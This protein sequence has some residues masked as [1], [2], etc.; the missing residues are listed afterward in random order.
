MGFCD[1]LI[2]VIADPVEFPH[3]GVIVGRRCVLWFKTVYQVP[4]IRFTGKSAFLD[5]LLKRLG[6]LLSSQN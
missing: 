2:E 3:H 5:L 6:F 1:D 4:K